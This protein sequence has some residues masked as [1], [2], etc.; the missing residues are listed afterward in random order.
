MLIRPNEAVTGVVNNQ[1]MIWP[2]VLE[3]RSNLHTEL[4]TRVWAIWDLPALS[5]EVICSVEE[6]LEGLQ[7]VVR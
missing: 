1:E 5:V 6:L 3:K 4:D 2:G 7:I